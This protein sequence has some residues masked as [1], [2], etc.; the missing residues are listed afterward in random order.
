MTASCWPGA[1][2]TRNVISARRLEWSPSARPS[3][4]GREGRPKRLKT[5]GPGQA[6]R[7]LPSGGCFNFCAQMEPRAPPEPHARHHAGLMSGALLQPLDL[8]S[9]FVPL[10]GASVCAP[11]RPAARPP[12]CDATRQRRACGQVWAR[13]APE[14]GARRTKR[15]QRAAV[16]GPPGWCAPRAGETVSWAGQMRQTITWSNQ[17]CRARARRRQEAGRNAQRDQFEARENMASYILPPDLTPFL[18]CP[19]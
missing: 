1:R 7:D 14:V 18:F 4:F 17:R 13:E 19:K 12:R 5:L 15:A 3:G 10:F 8:S 9:L 6:S 16:L 11:G 2:P